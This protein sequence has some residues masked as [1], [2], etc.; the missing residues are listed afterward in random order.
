MQPGSQIES[1]GKKGKKEK[2][3]PLSFAWDEKKRRHRRYAKVPLRS[4]RDARPITGALP[5][6]YD[7]HL[8][9]ST[10][11]LLWMKG[12]FDSPLLRPHVDGS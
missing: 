5:R 12:P 2:L 8:N 6:E 1:K 4:S 3:E 10:S 7:P 11:G 9:I